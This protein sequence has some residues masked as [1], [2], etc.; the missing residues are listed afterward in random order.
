MPIPK[1]SI[2]GL[3]AFIAVY[4]EQ[5]F[6]KAAVREN[7][8]QSGMSTQVKNLELKLDAPLL[9]RE[10]HEYSLTP[11]GQLVYR[12]G[13]AI[14]KALLATETAVAEIKDDV[15]GLVRFGLIPS[16]TRSVLTPALGSFKAEFAKV[17]LSLLEEYSGSL[18]RRVLDGELDFAF[19][20]SGDIP[21]GLTASFVARD[22]EFLVGSLAAR[23]EYPH[24]APAP[25]RALSGARLIVPSRLNVRRKGIDSLL[26]A[27]GIHVAELME[28]DGMLGTLEMV[29]HTDWQ[30]ILPSAICH[31]DK[32]GQV[33]KLNLLC[34][35]PMS[36][37]Y[38]IVQKSERPLPQA[39]RLLADH[40]A[41]YTNR[42]LGDWEDLAA[43]AI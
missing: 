31:P 20:P 33:R 21:A 19:V 41:T 30:A 40:L 35:P 12:E 9:V 6:S 16:L 32:D 28:M 13:C 23:P 14:L 38:V 43:P 29:A 42:I 39:A 11:A 22:R 5:S 24:L 34:D 1:I 25:L 10:R 17:E 18:M 26:K 15:A 36:F 4:E 27:H 2:N 8:T 3:R 37:D 7:A